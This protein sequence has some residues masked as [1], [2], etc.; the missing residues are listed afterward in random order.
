MT[1]ELVGNPNHLFETL[2]PAYKYDNPHNNKF[3]NDLIQ[4]GSLTSL[5]DFANK[6]V[7]YTVII[8][9]NTDNNY[10]I[11]KFGFSEDISQ[12]IKTLQYELGSPV[13][14]IK[15]KEI[16]NIQAEK[17]FQLLLKK[18]YGHLTEKYNSYRDL[19]RFTPAIL[20]E[21]DDFGQND[22]SNAISKLN[23]VEYYKILSGNGFRP[24]SDY[25]II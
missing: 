12:R 11:V 4:L 20:K 3:I 14:L 1:N 19:F 9:I 25:A 13:H 2:Y 22:P 5:N 8:K 23:N 16:P 15:C 17:I 21:F 24:D 18:K 6:C 7:L 10:V